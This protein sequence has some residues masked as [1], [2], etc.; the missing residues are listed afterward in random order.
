MPVKDIGTERSTIDKI[1]HIAAPELCIAEIVVRT[2]SL[3]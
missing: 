1:N 2:A 3:Q